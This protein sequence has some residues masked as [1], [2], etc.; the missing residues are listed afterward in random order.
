MHLPELFVFA[1]ACVGN[2]A[3]QQSSYPNRPIRVVVSS[4]E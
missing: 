1:I 3:A 4:K 2:A